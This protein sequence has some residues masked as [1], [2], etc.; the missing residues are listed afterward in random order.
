MLGL[1]HI[2]HIVKWHYLFKNLFLYSREWIRETKYIVMV[3]KG[4]SAK[5]VKYMSPGSWDLKLGRAQ[6]HF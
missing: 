4:G 2:N 6:M 5:S 1:D 3:T